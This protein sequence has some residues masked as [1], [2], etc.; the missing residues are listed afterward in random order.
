[1]CVC[2]CVYVIIYEK[3]GFILKLLKIYWSYK[4]YFNEIFSNV[5]L[6]RSEC[7][8]HRFSLVY[9]ETSGLVSKL[10]LQM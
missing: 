3:Q 4:L 6:L 5:I 2:V 1:M 8:G 10:F 9:P 7:F